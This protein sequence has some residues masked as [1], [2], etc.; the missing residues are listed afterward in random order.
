MRHSRFLPALSL[1]AGLGLPSAPRAAEVTLSVRAPLSPPAWALLQRELLRANTAACQEFFKRYYDER[2]YLLCVER[3]GGDDGPDDAIECCTD[4]PILHALG[5]PDVVLQRYKKAWEGHLRQYTAAKTR[6]VP[7][8][9]AGMYFKE[10]PVMFDWLHNAE[11]LTPF[12][13]QGL[14]DPYDRAFRQ[15]VRRFAGFYLNE[16]AGAPNYDPRHKIIRSLFNGS[17]GPLMRKATALDWAGD[18]IEVVNRFKLHHGERNYKEMLE[19]FQDYTD[20]LGDHPLNLLSTSLAVNAYMLRHEARYKRWLLEYVEAWRQRMLANDNLIPTN[21]GLDGKI[22]GACGGKWYGGVYGWA[23]SVKV[24]QTGATAHRNLHHKGFIGFMN[25]YLLTGDDRYLDVWRKQ[26]DAVN[27]H[28]KV[29]AGKTMYPT[30]YGDKG[31][32]AY[33]PQRYTRNARELYYLSLQPQ[34]RARTAP[35]RWL[36]YLEGKDA[37]YP[38]DA[39]RAD[40]ERV[41]RRV[42]G[43]RAD[44]TTPDTRLAD[45]PLPFGKAN[46]VSLIELCLGGIHLDRNAAVLHCRLRYFD[47]V[48]RRAGLPPDVAA[49][50]EKLT[51][52]AVTVQLVNISQLDARTVVIQAG[53]YA[54]H[55]FLT[56]EAEG[57][58]TAVNDSHFTVR[59]APGAGARLILSMRRYVNQ[60]VLAFPW[61]RGEAPAGK[62]R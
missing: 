16:D 1:L 13:V 17:R 31:W 38:E 15:R 5:A 29:S 28:K 52:D 43:M 34:D 37:R 25:A 19:H 11:G 8:A 53:G 9:R 36:A 24:P 57:R 46:I 41:R 51:A 18:P 10:F 32:Y 23:F 2:G 3:W 35:D 27:A 20:I 50:V 14:S 62:E 12:N 60:P 56:V 58:R 45:D 55:Q 33:V 54:E 42:Q 7:F 30:M 26:I 47:P 6:D 49:L 4:W 40:L 39:L 21:I 22:G 61:D 48:R 59:L 44:P